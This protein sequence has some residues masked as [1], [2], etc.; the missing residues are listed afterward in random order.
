MGE[1]VTIQAEIEEEISY[2]WQEQKQVIEKSNR[3]F[4]IC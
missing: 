3:D 4:Q 1:D 2:F